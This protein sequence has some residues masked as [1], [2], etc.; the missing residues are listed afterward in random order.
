MKKIIT[1]FLLLVSC[2]AA[3]IIY[4]NVTNEKID[5]KNITYN[6]LSKEKKENENLI[7]FVKQDGCTHCEKVKPVIN[8]YSKKKKIKVVAITINKEK[9]ESKFNNDLDIKGTPTIIFYHKGNEVNRIVGEF[10]ENQ[11][12]NIA[13]KVENER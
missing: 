9:N 13:R 11:F 10:S 8:N 12:L 7:L 2:T 1:F 6:K 3:F 5:Y 4:K